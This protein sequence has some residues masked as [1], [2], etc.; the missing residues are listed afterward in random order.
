[1]TST[2]VKFVIAKLLSFLFF[3]I[4]FASIYKPKL[5]KEKNEWKDALYVSV[6]NQTL[7]GITS[8]EESIKSYLIIQNIIGYVIL[9]GGLY[10]FLQ[11]N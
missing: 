2:K 3:A 5:P 4:M 10:L 9:I 11:I 7:T 1:M 8:D 6:L